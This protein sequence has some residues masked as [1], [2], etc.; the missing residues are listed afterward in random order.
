MQTYSVCSP[1]PEASRLQRQAAGGLCYNAV[2]GEDMVKSVEFPVS[3]LK[4]MA[5][6]AEAF[7]RLEEELE[8]YLLSRDLQFVA[9]MREARAAHLGGRVR[10][11]CDLKQELR[12][13]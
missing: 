6:A 3:L 2:G 7:S 12:I 5:H 9:R 13:E 1:S 10:P 8:D 4:R 11:L